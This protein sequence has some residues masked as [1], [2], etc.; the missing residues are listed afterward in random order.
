MVGIGEDVHLADR[1]FVG[2]NDLRGFADSGIGP[3]DT[4]T[5]DALGGNEFVTLQ[6]EMGFPIGLP[7]ELG[8]T[9]TVFSDIGTLTGI[10]ESGSSLVDKDSLRM[11]A[12][13]GFAWRSPFG[14]VRIYLA[15]A[16]IQADFDETEIFRF[17]F[18]TR[19]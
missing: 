4:S 10:D 9:G 2:G 11:S 18:G 8:I 3:R 15:K 6:A 17:T 13:A 7:K 19:F 12:G 14:P 5:K 16:L 1:F